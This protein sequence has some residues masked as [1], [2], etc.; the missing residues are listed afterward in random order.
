MN[1]IYFP[2]SEK[3]THKIKQVIVIN[4]LQSRMSISFSGGNQC[5][6]QQ[7]LGEKKK[8]IIFLLL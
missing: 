2:L 4:L 5:C 7:T 8:H 1:H 6:N 3:I